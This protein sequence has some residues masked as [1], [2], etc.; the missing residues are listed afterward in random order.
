MKLKGI[1]KD[2]FFGK[3]P[4]A[5][6]VLL[7]YR[8]FAVSVLTPFWFFTVGILLRIIGYSYITMNNLPG[9]FLNPLSW[10]FLFFWFVLLSFAGLIEQTFLIYCF[11]RTEQ[12]LEF[13]F[14][15]LWQCIM[16]TFAHPVK[17]NL[18]GA[19]MLSFLLEVLAVGSCT[20]FLITKIH[21][22][23]SVLNFAFASK[24]GTILMAVGIFLLLYAAALRTF[25]TEYF[26]LEKLSAKE[27]SMKNAALMR[28]SGKRQVVIS[29]L[30]PIALML[31]M[32]FSYAILVFLFTAVMR[33]FMSP[34]RV[35]AG[36]MKM[37]HSLD[38][39][40]L[41]GYDTFS[42]YLMFRFNVSRFYRLKERMNDLTSC[43]EEYGY[44]IEYNKAM[45]YVSAAVAVIM[46]A[47]SVGSCYGVIMNGLKDTGS[48]KGECS[49][50][51]H[52][53]QSAEAP[54]NTVP[55][56]LKAAAATAD[57]AE[58][59]VHMTADGKLVVMHDA[60]LKRTCG[61]DKQIIN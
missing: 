57:Y 38:Y 26:V 51:A 12:H 52:K 36:F 10:V 33:I 16:A 53:G 2:I 42:V 35:L 6:P 3:M 61:V 58:L 50:S 48:I 47:L 25:F 30:E 8:F 32:V 43:E 21:S 22:F 19:A 56:M 54:E 23:F 14:Q 49:F 27:S 1:M 15:E 9:F 41:V 46:L 39:L 45:K 18:I 55:A 31:I 44:S 20:P 5:L 13:R 29:L 60:S 37:S 28:R 17:R 40:F 11:S 24:A 4:I 34:D 59:D 7:L